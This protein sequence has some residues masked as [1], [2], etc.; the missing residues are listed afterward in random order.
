MYAVGLLV[1]FFFLSLQFLIF[2]ALGSFDL[3]VEK[4]LAAVEKLAI[5]FQT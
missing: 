1:F 4:P 5:V 3:F 2:F